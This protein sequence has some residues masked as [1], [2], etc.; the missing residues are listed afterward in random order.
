MAYGKSLELRQLKA[1]VTYKIVAQGQRKNTGVKTKD[2]VTVYP[3]T[4]K[5]HSGENKQFI[6]RNTSTQCNINRNKKLT[7]GRVI[8]KQY[9]NKGIGYDVETQRTF[10]QRPR[11][12]YT[13]RG[14]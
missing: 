5:K 14:Q 12:I 2:G 10:I 7:R 8:Q 6:K 3:L 11:I 9:V 13:Q 1:N 4:K